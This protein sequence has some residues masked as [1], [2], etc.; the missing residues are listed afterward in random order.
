[1]LFCSIVYVKGISLHL[2]HQGFSIGITIFKTI[3]TAMDG[4]SN[5]WNELFGDG[6][7]TT[8]RAGIG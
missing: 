8:L 6:A 5:Y 3:A 2:N 4:I 1:M 7:G